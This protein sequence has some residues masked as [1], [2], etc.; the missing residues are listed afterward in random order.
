MEILIVRPENKEQLKAI[1]AVLKALKVDFRKMDETDRILANPAM[2]K[3]LEESEQQLQEGKGVKMSLDEFA[4]KMKRGE[5]DI[6]AG[7]TA[8]IEP[9]DIWNLG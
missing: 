1:K 8:K 7:R 3:R 4:A 9:A 6:K 2:V 5:G